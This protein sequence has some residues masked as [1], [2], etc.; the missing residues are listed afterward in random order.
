LPSPYIVAACDYLAKA[1]EAYELMLDKVE[2][3]AKE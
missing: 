3:I 2:E 1:K